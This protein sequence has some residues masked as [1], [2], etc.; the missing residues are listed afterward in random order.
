MVGAL[1][2][3]SSVL[4][5]RHFRARGVEA[6][7]EAAQIAVDRLAVGAD[8]R[9]QLLGGQRQP[10]RPGDGA[11]HHRVDDRA[12]L[13]GERVH[14]DEQRVARIVRDGLD[15]LVLVEAAV[16]HGDLLVHGIEA[17][18]R[19]DQMRALGRDEAARH[20]AAGLEQFAR[21][22]DVDVADAGRERQHRALAAELARGDRENLDVIGGGAGA[23][24]DA[25]D[26]GALHRE[27]GL[28]RRRH[29]PVGQ[30]AAAFAAERGDQQGDGPRRAHAAASPP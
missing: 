12:A 21:H 26:R 1:R 6:G 28:G 20:H 13:F 11:E 24:G 29:D 23:L 22:R 17:A 10:P 27:A 15:Q 16:A 14:V 8:R 4:R 9:F 5:R 3:L 25:G 30:H 2:F 19:A 18:G 7:A